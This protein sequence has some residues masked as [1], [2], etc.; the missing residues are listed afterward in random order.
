[1]D[2]LAMPLD[3][4]EQGR[5]RTREGAALA[6]ALFVISAVAMLTAG[7]H[8]MTRSDIRTTT[9]R[10]SAVRA[11]TVAEAA[12]AHALAIM[13]DTLG[14]LSYTQFLQGPDG[15]P[16]NTDD[17]LLIGRTLSSGTGGND[18]PP[19]GR[20]YGGGRYTVTVVDDPAD[21]DGS[22][23]TDQ[24]SRVLVRCTGYGSDGSKVDLDVIIGGIT[25]PGFVFDGPLTVSGSPQ[26]VGRC[27]GTHANGAITISGA[28]T[29]SGPVSSTSTVTG[30]VVN[31]S[32]SPVT[33][34]QNQPAAEIPD[35]NP[36]RL[37]EGARYL[38]RSDGAVFDRTISTTV[39]I[40][41]ATSTPV[42]GFKRAS[43]PPA[44]LW[45]WE[46]AGSV[47]GS[48]CFDGNVEISGN[49]GTST[50]PQR[51]SLYASGSV[52]ISGNPQ[53]RSFDEDSI[54]VAAGGDL[55]I[56]GNP[57]AGEISYGGAMYAR[58]QCQVSG[59]PV[60]NGQLICDNEPGQPTTSITEW[61]TF[62]EIN[63]NPQLTYGC[64]NKW[65][66]TRRY[67]GWMQQQGNP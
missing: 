56:A 42:L 4:S 48:F 43:A 10:E 52:S 11:L 15:F 16:G 24:N 28:L 35:M 3:R 32:G 13:R 66:S 5:N 19:G 64:N 37:C 54:L 18:I 46:K 25:M 2:R 27:G 55:K 49:P 22:A 51:W 67:M 30:S 20:A 53:L 59:N 47:D 40:G 50:V 57:K 9:N 29:T 36:G 38:M 45:T 23:T 63:G 8:W 31:E 39:P 62:N 7:V 33:P 6:T 17:G 14:E 26:T 12:A 34:L 44:T 1:M 41:N 21:T 61:V 60:I 65:A 58:Y